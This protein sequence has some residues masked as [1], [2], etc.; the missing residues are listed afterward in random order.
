[1]PCALRLLSVS[2]LATALLLMS[3]C[4]VLRPTPPPSR[5]PEF[6][7]RLE[8]TGPYNPAQRAVVGDL[9]H[10]TSDLEARP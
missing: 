2:T 8:A 10:Y 5:I 4:A 1:M 3:G 6:L 9:L 7:E